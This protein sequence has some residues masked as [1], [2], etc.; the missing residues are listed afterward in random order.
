MMLLAGLATAILVW[1]GLKFFAG[2]NPARL[3]KVSR[4]AGGVAALGAAGLLMFRGRMDMAFLLGSGGAWLLGWN[5]LPM[6]FRL[7]GSAAKRQ[8]RSVSRVR[9]ARIEMVLDH[10][11]GTISGSVLAGP[12]AGRSLDALSE[13]DLLALRATCLADDRDGARLVETYLDRRDPL[14]REHAEPDADAR[15]RPDAEL[16]AMSQEEAHQ[17]LGLQPGAGEDAVRA[18]HRT[19][20]KKLHPDQ[21]GSTYLASRVN[22]A[23]DALL[24]RHR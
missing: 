4:T 21:G 8:P 1:W 13:A 19:L 5:A 17:V 24:N 16:S 20:M 22:Q 23:K 9:S 3:A 7:G 6:P 11:S 15:G 12:L 14:W 2:T 10:D 18:A